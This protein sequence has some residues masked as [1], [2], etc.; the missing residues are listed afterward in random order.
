MDPAEPFISADTFENIAIGVIFLMLFLSAFFSGTETALT[1]ASRPLMHQLAKQGD[2][3]AHLVN[4]LRQNSDRLIGAIL[5]GN[6]LSNILASSL[7]TTLLIKLFG[8]AGV[9]Y[10]TL[11]MTLLVLIF[12]EVLPKTYA[13]NNADRM[14]RVVAPLILPFVTL[15]SPVTWVVERI[16][17]A[18]L[19]MMGVA[20]TTDIGASASD[21]ELRGAIELHERPGEDVRAERAML[22]SI[23]DLE[24]V[25]V[26]EIMTHRR[27]VAM[28]DADAPTEEL[29]QAIIES[30]FTRMPLYRGDTDNIVGVVHAKALLREVS[31]REGRLGEADLTAI[32]SKP[33]FIPDTTTLADQLQAFK[34]RR[35]HFA[36]VIDEYGSLMGIVT[37]EDI[38]EEIVGE[39]DDETDVAMTGVVRN[40]DGSLLVDGTVTLRDLN[41]EFEWDLPDEDASTLAGLVLRE[42]RTIPEV[43]QEFMFYGFRFRITRRQR[44]QI[45]QI[46]LTPPAKPEDRPDPEKDS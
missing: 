12:S 40:P 1:A 30:P 35:E 36:M 22:R 20:M 41:R 3:R 37:L 32:A 8:D 19:R 28:L 10:A 44:N 24:D 46:R 2:K 42:A 15:F 26:S 31:R 38:I 21:E 11:A 7:A 4:S 23:L 6:N 29:V 13:I 39:I 5:L 33:W 16:V 25:D 43:G 34:L 17:R 14:S 45:T 9:A 18:T 27:N